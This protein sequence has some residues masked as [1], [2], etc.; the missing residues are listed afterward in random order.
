MTNG[1]GILRVNIPGNAAITHVPKTS[2]EP[3]PW[4]TVWGIGL[5]LCGCMILRT[6]G[7]NEDEK[8]EK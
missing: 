2:D 7:R 5:A 3:F 1:D 8:E 4:W 6:A